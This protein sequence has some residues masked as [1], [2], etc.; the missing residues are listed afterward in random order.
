MRS[1]WLEWLLN[2][3][4]DMFRLCLKAA[5]MEWLAVSVVVN[6]KLHPKI[7]WQLDN[8]LR[9]RRHGHPQPSTACTACISL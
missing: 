7:L 4:H 9:K 2:T 5:N 3:E 6:E 8:Q 1:R